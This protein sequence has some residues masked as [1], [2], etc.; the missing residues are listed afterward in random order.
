MF[1]HENRHNSFSFRLMELLSDVYKNHEIRF[2]FSAELYDFPALVYKR[3]MKQ[4]SGN[5]LTDIVISETG[6][7]WEVQI[8]FWKRRVFVRN[9]IKA[10]QKKWEEDE[11]SFLLYED[12]GSFQFIPPEDFYRKEDFVFVSNRAVFN[13]I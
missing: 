12:C 4:Y 2:D 10:A 9:G 5:F 11:M 6:K 7:L 8:L 3:E 13:A 1:E